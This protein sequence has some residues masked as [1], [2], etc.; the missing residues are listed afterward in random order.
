MKCHDISISLLG[1][2]MNPTRTF[3]ILD[4]IRQP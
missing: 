1:Y 3:M 4:K 2:D